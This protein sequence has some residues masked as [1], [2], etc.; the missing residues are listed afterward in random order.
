MT[1]D[2]D[3][4]MT[5]ETDPDG[6]VTT[7]QYDAQNRATVV[8]NPLGNK[9][10]TM[11]DNAG[12]ISTITDA[13]GQERI[14]SY[15]NA[16]RETG[17]VWK[18]SGGT[19]VNTLTFT[20]DSNGNEL[21]AAN[22]AGTYTMT[23]NSN[24]QLST[25]QG[26]YGVSLT[27]SYDNNGN[28]TSLQDS[29]AGVMTVVYNGDNEWTT[30]E[31][32][33]T[34]MSPMQIQRTYNA[35]GQKATDARYDSLTA[36]STYE[37]GQ[38]VYTWSAGGDL[39]NETFKNGSGSTTIQQVT[40]TYDLAHRATSLDLNGTTKSY[41]YDN[42]N[43]LTNDGVATYSYDN[44]GNRNMTGYTTGTGN[45][46][47]NDGVY[48]YT[49]DADGN[50]IEKSKGTGLE[51][52][53]YTYDNVGHLLTVNETTNGTTSEMTATY[54]YDAFGNLVKEIEWQTG[55]GTTTTEHVYNGTTLFMDLNGS[56]ALQMRY[57]AGDSANEWLGREDG[58]GNTSW[59]LTDRLGSVIGLTNGSG[60]ATDTITYDGFGNKTSETA[61]MV[62]G[63]IGFQGMYFD[64]LVGDYLDFAR[65]YN[66]SSAKFGGPDPIGL[67]SGVS[68]LY[69]FVGNDATNAT[70]PLGTLSKKV[71]V[72][73][74]ANQVTIAAYDDTIALAPGRDG[75]T[76]EYI[77]PN[78]KKVVMF[79]TLAIKA[80]AFTYVPDKD[81]TTLGGGIMKWVP[82]V[83]NFSS[84]QNAPFTT[85]GKP[86]LDYVPGRFAYLTSNKGYTGGG[87]DN[88]W[89]WD[90]PNLQLGILEQMPVA[91]NTTKWEDD[92]H[93]VTYVQYGPDVIANVRWSIHGDASWKTEYSLGIFPYKVRNV[94]SDPIQ[95]DG[96]DSGP[97]LD[98][99]AF[100][101]KASHIEGDPKKGME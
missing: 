12:R 7:F 37:V 84:Y 22:S 15:D 60:T 94:S 2:G 69:G 6:N 27:Y 72:P 44:N 101:K 4:N 39:T 51:T 56:N 71:N 73:G 36:S 52:W 42:A 53:Y 77:G 33:G 32:N 19:T 74:L 43:E 78:P 75:I 61:P 57:M 13:L 99:I 65:P 1:Y 17:E 80:R 98:G 68:N 18:N 62:T 87:V 9:T 30:K 46:L 96:I 50:M 92:L 3:G 70:D 90:G 41:S 82:V 38:T 28:V 58:I 100:E 59:D 49:Y 14:F 64:A 55:V 10:T 85:D 45:Q 93:F 21:T 35:D 95:I 76:V 89:V 16:N 83:F 81:P 67:A 26:L 11:Y 48:T 91:L 23:Y 97:G 54:T 5:S 34:G 25:V 20:Y 63:E 79:Q 29:F 8:I 24:N 88:V 66:P 31:W 40:Y 47:T 86:R